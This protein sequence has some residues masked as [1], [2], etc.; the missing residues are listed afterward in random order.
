VTQFRQGGGR[1]LTDVV[2]R[3][4]VMDFRGSCQPDEAKV[5]VDFQLVLA[6]ERGPAFDGR[7]PTY[8]YFV[9]VTDREG[10]VLAKQVFEATMRFAEGQNRAG[11]VEELHQTIPLAQGRR[12]AD[13]QVL[14]GFQLTPDQLAFNRSEKAF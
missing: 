1:D 2:S 10:Q 9:A 14:V 11:S 4:A 5:D 6:T 3:G 12:P 8:Q 13:Y 7:D